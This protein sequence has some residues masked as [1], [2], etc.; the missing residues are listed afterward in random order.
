[1]FIAFDSNIA[2][3]STQFAWV[4]SELAASTEAVPE[5]ALFFHHPPFS[6]GP[7]GG[8]MVEAQARRSCDEVDANLPAASVR[9][10]L[11]GHE[12]LFEHWVE[13][14]TDASG[15]TGWTRS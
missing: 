12:H 15:L 4:K 1:M 7:H 6:S 3:D 2:D 11:T 5:V 9:L 13:R 10:L 8:A 14:Y